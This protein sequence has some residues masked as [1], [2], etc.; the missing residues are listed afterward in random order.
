MQIVRCPFCRRYI[1]ITGDTEG[2]GGGEEEEEEDI[3][4][5][6]SLYTNGFINDPAGI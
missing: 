2:V 4:L 3:L 6:R 1:V 5:E